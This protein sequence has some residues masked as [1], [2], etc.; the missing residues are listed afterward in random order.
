MKVMRLICLVLVLCLGK[1]GLPKCPT[2]PERAI[3]REVKSSQA[4]KAQVKKGYVAIAKL[5]KGVER[6]TPPIASAKTPFVDPISYILE[7]EGK[8]TLPD[9]TVIETIRPEDLIDD[10]KIPK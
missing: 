7:K 5:Q 1:E 8:V 6:K 4:K 3:K 2:C 9:G 10:S